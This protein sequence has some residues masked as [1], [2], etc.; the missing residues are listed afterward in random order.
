MKFSVTRDALHFVIEDLPDLHGERFAAGQFIFKKGNVEIEVF[1]I[2][3]VD[4]L[5]FYQGAEFLKVDH[6]PGF[7]IRFPFYSDDN[8]EIVSMPV[9]VSTWAEYLLVFFGGPGGV[10]KF[11]SGVEVLFPANVNHDVA[12]IANLRA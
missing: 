12:N 11:V 8:F 5:I 3:L 2:E 4:D 9:L 10:V 6:K 7:R 1:M